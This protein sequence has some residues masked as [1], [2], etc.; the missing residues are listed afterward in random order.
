VVGIVALHQVN[1]FISVREWDSQFLGLFPHRY[2]YIWAVH[3]NPGAKPEWQTET[4]H[5][6][7]DR[8]IQQGSQL[9]GVRFGTETSYAML[10]IDIGSRYHPRQDP[11]G[12]DRLLL[13]LEPLGLISNLTVQSSHSGGLHLYFP[14]EQAQTSW[15]I[16]LAISTLLESAGFKL[17]PGQLE[18][19]P[20]PKPYA[21]D[22]KPSLFGAHRLPLQMGSYLLDRDY[23]PVAYSQSRFVEQWI[24]STNRND[25]DKKQL[26]RLIKQIKRRCFKLSGKADKFLN[27]LNAEIELGWTGYGQTNRLLGRVAMRTYVFHHILHGGEPLTGDQ[28]VQE[29]TAITKALPGYQDWCQHQHEITHRTAEWARCVE[30]SHYFPYGTKA[31]P[32][33]KD[34]ETIPTISYNQQRLED[35]RTRIKEA[36]AD[37]LNRSA[38]PSKATER[39]K[40]LLNYGIGGGSLYRHKDLWHPSFLNSHNLTIDPPKDCHKPTNLLDEIDGN[41]NTNN[42]SIDVHLASK[43]DLVGNTF[44]VVNSVPSYE[45]IDP[46]VWLDIRQAAATEMLQNSFD[47]ASA[48]PIDRMQQQLYTD[49]PILVAEAWA[50]AQQHPDMPITI[51]SPS[52]VDHLNG[53]CSDQ[54]VAI[55]IQIDR[56]GWSKAQVQAELQ[57]HF[58]CSRSVYLSP[59]QLAEWL[60]FLAVQSC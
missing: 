15:K 26:D 42:A 24:Y 3:P 22:G 16:A 4:R 57:H 39:F 19:F 45:N 33:P 32:Q 9:Y 5:P 2:D 28:L 53:D 44:S 23:Q 59:M 40:S 27:D 43:D 21:T 37:L 50:W 17:Y 55:T 10:D 54:L 1:P 60:A 58:G 49:D 52:L 34:N 30:E 11:F 51:P 36:T 38:L 13:A 18:I 31:T 56:L 48:M 14:F 8:T 12:V 20:N 35:A 7:A 25:L 6:L 41:S 47:S 46:V 29:I